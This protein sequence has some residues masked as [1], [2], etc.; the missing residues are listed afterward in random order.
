MRQLPALAHN[1]TTHKSQAT[2]AELDSFRPIEDR[3]QQSD[4]Y[5]DVGTHWAKGDRL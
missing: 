2:A 1:T 3:I 5:M 4:G